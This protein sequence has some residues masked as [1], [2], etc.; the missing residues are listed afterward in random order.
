[1]SRYR[2]PIC[3]LCRVEKSKLFLKGNKCLTD[4]CPLERRAYP[5]GQHGRSRRRIL[6]YGIQLREKQKLKRYYGMSEK[7]FHLFFER[8][9]RQKGITGETLLAM[10][11]RR[12]DNV[13]FLTGFA[14]SRAHAR[15]L[16]NHGHFLVN[17][18]RVTIPSF[19]VKAG[20]VVTF[21][22]RSAKSEDVKAMLEVH[23]NKVVPGW[24]EADWDGK[25][26]RIVA[27]PTRA[28]ITMPIEEHMVVE[29]YSK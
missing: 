23:K 21:R 26:A 17:E 14:H 25:T 22:E 27:L 9:E 2:E 8:A 1:M 6:G 4:K 3:R 28:D 11:E 5:P 13:V 20:D 7:Q 24:L 19:Q 18:S 10:L 29:L 16:I 12:L 15:Q